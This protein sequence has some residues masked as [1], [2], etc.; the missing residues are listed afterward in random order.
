MIYWTYKSTHTITYKIKLCRTFNTHHTYTNIET[1][2]EILHILPKGP[3]LNTTKQYEIYKHYKQSPTNILNYQIQYKSHTLFTVAT[4]ISLL[5]QQP[6][7][8]TLQPVPL[9]PSSI[10]NGAN[11]IK[12]ASA[13]NSSKLNKFLHSEVNLLIQHIIV[14]I[15]KVNLER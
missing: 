11:G 3:K 9:G 12:K 7:T 4:I 8:G 15:W 10:E 6:W 14:Q 5:S 1:N 2:L 13:K